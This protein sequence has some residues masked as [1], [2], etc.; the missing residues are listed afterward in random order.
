[1]IKSG[2]KRQAVH[3]AC[4][5]QRDHFRDQSMDGRTILR[6]ILRKQGVCEWNKFIWLRIGSCDGL[7][8]KK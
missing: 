2:R 8:W 6:G 7:L 5:K 4:L 3:T 1:M